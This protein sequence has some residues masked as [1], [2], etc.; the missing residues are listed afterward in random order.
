VED[1]HFV[2]QNNRDAAALTF[3]DVSAEFEEERLNLSPSNVRAGG[4]CVDRLKRFLMLA[5]HVLNGTAEQ[6]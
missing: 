4:A 1:T 6:Y 2:E 3:A 5:P